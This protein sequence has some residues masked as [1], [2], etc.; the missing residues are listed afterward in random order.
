[1]GTVPSRL[2]LQSETTCTDTSILLN[3]FAGPSHIPERLEIAV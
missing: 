2:G 3:A 1:M